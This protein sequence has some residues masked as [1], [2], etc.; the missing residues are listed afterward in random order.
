MLGLLLNFPYPAR[1]RG[2]IATRLQKLTLEKNNT[3]RSVMNIEDPKL[4]NDSIARVKLKTG[5]IIK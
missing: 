2:K 3:S 5:M 1:I 4:A